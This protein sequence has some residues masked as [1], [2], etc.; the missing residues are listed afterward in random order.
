MAV[1]IM[2]VVMSFDLRF[3]R[4]TVMRMLCHGMAR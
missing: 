3:M 4:M 2:M 1:A